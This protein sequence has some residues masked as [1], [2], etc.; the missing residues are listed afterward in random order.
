MFSSG[1]ILSV[2]IA[3]EISI[4][5]ASSAANSQFPLLET[6]SRVNL[7]NFIQRLDIIVVATLILGMFIKVFVFFYAGFIGIQDLF[8][9][10]TKKQKAYCILF[11]SLLIFISSIQMSRNFTEHIEVGLKWVPIYLHL[12]LQTGIPLL[13]FFILLLRKG[14]RK[15]KIST[16][17]MVT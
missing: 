3:L 12:P 4:I 10:K 7:A 14:F 11:L 15:N 5:G 17:D 9:I 16:P 1:L 8:P 2:T 6:V 13:L